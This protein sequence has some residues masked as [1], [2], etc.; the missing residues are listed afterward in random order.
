MERLGLNHTPYDGRHTFITNMKRAGANEYILKKIVGH[1]IKDV[2]ENVYTHRDISDLIN[3]V[4]K[5]K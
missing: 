2:T 5:I 4:K 3:E 1:S